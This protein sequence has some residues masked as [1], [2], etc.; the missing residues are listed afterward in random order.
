[1][2]QLTIGPLTLD[3]LGRPQRTPFSRA[4]RQRTR[5]EAAYNLDGVMQDFGL[6]E[7]FP[8]VFETT[9][10][11]GH[12]TTAQVRQLEALENAGEP[13]TLQ[14]DHF[15]EDGQLETFSAEFDTNT[16]A[17][18]TPVTPAGDFYAYSIP[19]YLRPTG[20]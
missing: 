18:Y 3:D 17:L 13:F 5:V 1:M 10:N 16:R 6:A 11:V 2:S 4:R 9:G 14:T 19:L 20:G 12:L 7:G 15:G 8:Y